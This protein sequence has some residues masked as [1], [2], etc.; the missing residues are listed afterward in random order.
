MQNLNIK[1]KRVLFVLVALVLV[2]SVQ[3]IGIAGAKKIYWS[4][5]GKIRRANLDGSNVENV[6]TGLVYTK[7]ISLDFRNNTIFWIEE[8]TAKVKGVKLGYSK[9]MRADSDGSNIEEIIG[10]YHIPPEGGGAL[11]E[12]KGEVCWVWIEP[13]G[14]D[15]VEIDPEQYLQPWGISLDNQKQHIYWIDRA[16]RKFQRAN[17]DGTG[18]KDVMD[19]KSTS[20]WDMKLD[21]KRGQLYWVELVSR[22][23]Q[24]VDL[25]GTDV[26]VV[27]DRWNNP[28]LSI[29]LD[30]DAQHI[31]WT[32][33]SSGIIHRASLDG[34][35][36]EEV[37]TGLKKPNHLVVDEQ[38]SKMYWSTR[39]QRE[40]THKIQQ[41]NLDGSDV[42]DVVTD[43]G[44]I[45]GLA[46]DFEGIY[47]VDPAGKLTTVWA[48]VKT[49]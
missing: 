11:K 18:V 46:L 23:I 15:R 2:V 34:A 40:D 9:I 13:E 37:I 7:D 32:S 28:I 5:W 35:N 21:V 14:K 41:A 38:F 25:D 43:L 36:I 12:C 4:E 3:N 1:Q 29:G 26:E 22:M 17:L 16:H 31:Y 39:D 47:A 45:N 33:T 44:S 8:G 19:L 20:V 24:R 6:I 27:V 10:G 48:D 49:D 30:V 42:R